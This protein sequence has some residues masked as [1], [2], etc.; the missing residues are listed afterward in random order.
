[1]TAAFV[2]TS[3]IAESDI[4]E[5]AR[6]ISADSLISAKKFGLEFSEAL[7]RI[8]AFPLSG[9]AVAGKPKFYV[10]RVSARF[11]RY[12]IVYRLDNEGVEIQRILHSAMDVQA[13][14]DV[15]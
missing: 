12:L 1:M 2:V 4:E 6:Y 11:W 3:A 15:L 14:L 13:K 10:M 7:N 5:I 9:H 8:R